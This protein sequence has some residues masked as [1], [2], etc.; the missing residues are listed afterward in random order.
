MTDAI[1]IEETNRIRAAIGLKLLPVPGGRPAGPTFKESSAKSKDQQRDAAGNGGDG[2]DEEPGSTLESRQGAAY[3]NWKKLQDEAASKAARQARSE[4]VKKARDAA[5]RLAVL[6]GR[7]LGEAEDDA[8]ADTRT[9]LLRQTKRQK[10]IEKARRLEQELA[11]REQAMA[12][13][14]A[15]GSYTAKDLAGVKVGHELDEFEAGA[16]QVLTLKDA[17]IDEIEEEGDELENV[18]LR[19]KEKLVDRLDAKKRTL[20]YN[21]NADDDEGGEKTVLSKYD[22]E[23]QGKKKKAFTLGKAEGN[24]G[25]EEGQA[26]KTG[27]RDRPKAQVLNLDIASEF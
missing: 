20:T 4:A 5:Q 7:G 3:D 12:A 24:E 9:W 14:A 10:K 2:G 27:T 23:I 16:A 1:S 25:E 17:T 15:A 22:E 21:P 13:A 8:D 11:E 18:E 26:G 6:Q 19:E